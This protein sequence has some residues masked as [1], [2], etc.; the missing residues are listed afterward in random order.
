VIDAV[1]VVPADE[2][3]PAVLAGETARLRSPTVETC[4]SSWPRTTSMLSRAASSV[5]PA[6]MT[7]RL[8]LAGEGQRLLGGCRQGGA[9][10][11]QGEAAGRMADGAGIIG[12]ADLELTLGG[13]HLRF[14]L[15]VRGLLLGDVGAGQFADLGADAR[16]FEFL[17]QHVFVVAG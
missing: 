3:P 8:F 7:F 10:A 12:A 11:R 13:D 9:L 4:G 6:E 16:R 15:L 5:K 1:V 2:M 17:T 14:R